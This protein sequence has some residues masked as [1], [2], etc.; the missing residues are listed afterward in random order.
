VYKYSKIEEKNHEYWEVYTQHGTQLIL[1]DNIDI[2]EF[3]P[4]RNKS[5]PY[6]ITKLD[7][8]QLHGRRLEQERHVEEEHEQEEIR[9]RTN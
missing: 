6:R 8:E 4:N 1:E 9:R 5:R 7:N 3:D 2:D